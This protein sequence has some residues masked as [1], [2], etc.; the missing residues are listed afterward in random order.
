MHFYAHNLSSI[1]NIRSPECQHPPRATRDAL[2]T[3]QA[4]AVFDRDAHPGVPADIDTDRTVK[5]TNSTLNTPGWIRDH[6]P[7]DNYLPPGSANG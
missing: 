6:L 7:L 4:S 3:C 2:T 1:E 5:R